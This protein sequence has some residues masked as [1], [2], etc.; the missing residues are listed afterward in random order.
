[1]GV[2][3]KINFSDNLSV[4]FEITL[5]LIIIIITLKFKKKINF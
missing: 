1:M 3:I 4:K 2:K 5:R